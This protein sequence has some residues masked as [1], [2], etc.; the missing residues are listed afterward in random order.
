L[1]NDELHSLYSSPNIVR[2]IKSMRMRWVGHVARMGEGR[3]VY[4]VLVGRPEGKRPPGRPRRRWEDNI[5]MDIREIGIDGAN[6]IQLAQDRIQWRV[7]VHTVM[8]LRIP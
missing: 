3:C 8:N 4:R 5:K 1:H 2:V 7:C 6:W